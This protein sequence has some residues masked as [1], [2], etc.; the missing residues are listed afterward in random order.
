M[1]IGTLLYILKIYLKIT[2]YW[3]AKLVVLW[4]VLQHEVYAELKNHGQL[5]LYRYN[6]NF[7]VCPKLVLLWSILTSIYAEQKLDAKLQLCGQLKIYRQLK[8]YGMM[9][10]AQTTSTGGTGR[11]ATFTHTCYT[12]FI[13]QITEEHEVQKNDIPP[14]DN[15]NAPSDRVSILSF[16]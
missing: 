6:G 11:V 7:L 12:C 2:I 16:T 15:D 1:P 3:Y 14:Q 8:I 13:F 10:W 9:H 5:Y 4:S